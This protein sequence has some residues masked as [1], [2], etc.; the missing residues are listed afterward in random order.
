MNKKTVTDIDVKDK[1][2]LV[3]VD[4]NVP[5]SSKD[6]A[7]DIYVTDDTRIQAALPTINYLLDNGAALILCSHLGRPKSPADLQ[8]AMDPVA[9]RLSEIL[10][11]DIIKMDKVVGEAVTGAAAKL[12][13]G[14]IMLLENTRFESG[15]KKN[16][17]ELSRQLAG[18]ADVYVNDAFGSAHRAHASTEGVAQM[19]REEGNPAVAGFL[20][21]KEL[22]ALSVAV[23]DPPHPYIA[24]MGGAKISDKIKLI[25]HLLQVTD[26]ILIGGGMANTFL[27]AQD[28]EVGKSLVEEEAIPEARRLLDTA[29]DRLILPVDVVVAESL[30]EDT[31]AQDVPVNEIPADKMALDVGLVTIQRFNVALQDARLVVWNGPMGVFEVER[32]AAGTNG[33]AMLLGGLAKQ[34]TTV[35]VGGGDS[36]A[37]VAKAGLSDQMSHVSTGGG[38]SLEFL[39]GKTLPGIAA[40]DEVNGSSS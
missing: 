10:D 21:E 31:E 32:F 14:Q 5:L 26:K 22:A 35:I 39:E 13:P 12:E 9:D 27:K 30:E 6:P 2:V 24:I 8:F 28:L 4:F 11:L 20:M 23:N 3:R 33:L 19:M 1:K 29:G 38:A 7:D 40:L 17:P 18:L 25:E 36:A 37:A 16:D 34:G 15:E